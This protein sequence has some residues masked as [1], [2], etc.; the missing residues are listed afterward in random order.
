MRS[1]A[2]AVAVAAVA[3]APAAA[4][5]I[6]AE[7]SGK[8]ALR[9]VAAEP[10]RVAGV[11]FR[12]RERVRVVAVVGD[13]RAAKLVRASGTGTFGVAFAD[14]A[15]DRCLTGLVVTAS[16]SA[17]SRA[18]AKLPKLLCPPPLGGPGG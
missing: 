4:G 16:G 9:I 7:A 8:A 14:L 1:V 6:G 18:S 17:G 10:V 13:V 12:P 15:A 3:V 11:G 2:L 5:P